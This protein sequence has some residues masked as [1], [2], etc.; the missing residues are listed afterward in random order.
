MLPQKRA[1]GDKSNRIPKATRSVARA[2]HKPE[3]RIAQTTIN[4]KPKED[5]RKRDAERRLA[6][7]NLQSDHRGFTIDRCWERV[8][9]RVVRENL[10]KD[11]RVWSRKV[12]KRKWCI[13]SVAQSSS[14]SNRTG[15]ASSSLS[16]KRSNLCTR[17][18]SHLPHKT[19]WI[20]GSP[21]SEV[22]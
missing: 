17:N 18:C 9:S 20:G 21:G 4:G 16:Q 6:I 3:T 14:S 7:P 5:P 8:S 13:T 12:W 11:G 19:G 10:R 22:L 1:R 15:V 2:D